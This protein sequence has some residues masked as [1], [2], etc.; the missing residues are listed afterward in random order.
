MFEKVDRLM[1][2]GLGALSMSKEKAEEIFD[3]YVQ[4]GKTEQ[5]N[6][7]GFIKE[8]MNSADKTREELEKMISKQ[9][10]QAVD[11]LDVATKKDIKRLETKLDELL[12]KE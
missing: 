11:K 12:K 10:H 6:K 9:V 8:M 1:L 2:A 3:E 4:K 5:A 7:K